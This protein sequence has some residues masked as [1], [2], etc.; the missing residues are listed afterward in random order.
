MALQAFYTKSLAEKT[1][2]YPYALSFWSGNW[3]MRRINRVPSSSSD[4]TYKVEIFSGFYFKGS[5]SHLDTSTILSGFQASAADKRSP[6]N[7]SFIIGPPTV[8]KSRQ[9][10]HFQ[11][12]KIQALASSMLTTLEGRFK[13]YFVVRPLRTI[14][15]GSVHVHGSPAGPKPKGQIN[16]PTLHSRSVI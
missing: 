10:P 15:D 4:S 14:P 12:R 6:G 5:R 13:D 8:A 16:L 3:P 1:V 2:E 11:Y 9:N 7:E